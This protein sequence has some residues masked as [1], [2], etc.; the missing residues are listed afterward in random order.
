VWP[1]HSIV[2]LGQ[3]QQPPSLPPHV[4]LLFVLICVTRSAGTWRTGNTKGQFINC[5]WTSNV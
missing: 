1:I 5:I 2:R 4:N 3:E